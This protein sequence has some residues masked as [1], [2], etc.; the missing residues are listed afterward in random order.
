MSDLDIERYIQAVRDCATAWA[1][2]KGKLIHLTH[3]RQALLAK[4]YYQAPPTETSVGAREKWA[5]AS[6]EYKAFLQGLEAAVE[7]EANTHWQLKRAEM[8]VELWRTQQ[9]TQRLERK[10]YNA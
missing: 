10:A 2:A 7:L 9:A 3:Y 1:T 4:L 6:E 8:K 5:L